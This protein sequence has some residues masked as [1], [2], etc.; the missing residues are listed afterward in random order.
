MITCVQKVVSQLSHLVQLVFFH[1][2]YA[3]HTWQSQTLN[4]VTSREIDF[5]PLILFSQ[6]VHIVCYFPNFTANSF[7]PSFH[8]FPIVKLSLYNMLPVKF[9]HSCK[10]VGHNRKKWHFVCTWHQ[11]I[12]NW[13]MLVTNQEQI[14]VCALPPTRRKPLPR[15]KPVM[16]NPPHC[17][18]SSPGAWWFSQ[19]V[20]MAVGFLCS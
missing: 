4:C 5:P 20:P 18:L 12:F 3:V 6:A 8:L 11:C 19:D 9:M 10:Q 2:K 1:S 17:L 14:T 16:V 13:K 15:P 7:H